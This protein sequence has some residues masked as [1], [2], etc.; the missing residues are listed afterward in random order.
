MKKEFP[1]VSV[2]EDKNNLDDDEE[3]PQA[4][5]EEDDDKDKPQAQIEEDDEEEQPQAKKKEIVCIICDKTVQFQANVLRCDKNENHQAHCACLGMASIPPGRWQCPQC[6]DTDDELNLE[7]DLKDEETESDES[8]C[9]P[10]EERVPEKKR[11]LIQQKEITERQHNTERPSKHVR[12]EVVASLA[13]KAFEDNPPKIFSGE[14]WLEFSLWLH[15]VLWHLVNGLRYMCFRAI[16]QVNALPEDLGTDFDRYMIQKKKILMV[17]A[18][19]LFRNLASSHDRPLP[20]QE[21]EEVKQL[22]AKELL[23]VINEQKETGIFVKNSQLDNAQ[24]RQNLFSEVAERWLG[25]CGKFIIPVNQLHIAVIRDKRRESSL[26]QGIIPEV[27]SN[28]LI[29]KEDTSCEHVLE[30]LP[31][32]MDQINNGLTLLSCGEIKVHLR[33]DV[34]NRLYTRFDANWTRESDEIII[35]N[36]GPILS[37]IEMP[38]ILKTKTRIIPLKQNIRYTTV[39]E[40]KQK[41]IEEKRAHRKHQAFL[42]CTFCMLLPYYDL[43]RGDAGQH[44]VVPKPVFDVLRDWG[45][46]TEG[47]ATPFNATLDSYHSPFFNCDQFFGSSGSFFRSPLTQGNFQVNPPFTLNDSTVVDTMADSLQDAED[48]NRPLSFVLIHTDSYQKNVDNNRDFKQFI[49]RRFV[50]PQSEHYYYEGAFFQKSMPRAYKPSQGSLIVFAMTTAAKQKWPIN[51]SF[52]QSFKRAFKWP[53]ISPDF[54]FCSYTLPTNLARTQLPQ[55]SNTTSS[56]SAARPP[57][58]ITLPSSSSI[59]Q[60]KVSQYDNQATNFNHHSSN[61]KEEQKK[62]PRV[63][64]L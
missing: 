42:E 5:L 55:F 44:G 12:R 62:K 20:G 29:R 7:N 34:L 40:K 49:V 60:K 64:T 27:M 37:D 1:T 32:Q 61:E 54:Y 31:I 47:F 63:A 16:R 28:E 18:A 23:D 57:L 10:L 15:A 3:P 14:T 6:Q 33:K 36:E 58:P 17:Y 39:E 48:N 38:K 25:E 22:V 4:I 41:Q 43:M 11:K 45:C 51:D 35:Q 59:A 46:T 9:S 13:K 19:A 26:C 56:H 30:P 24:L 52:I 8:S 50:I 2:E 53:I 21:K